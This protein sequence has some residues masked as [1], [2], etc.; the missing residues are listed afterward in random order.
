MIDYFHPQPEELAQ[1]FPFVPSNMRKL[2]FDDFVLSK[3][4]EGSLIA[5]RFTNVFENKDVVGLIQP[6]ILT[7]F[8]K[9]ISIEE[10]GPIQEYTRRRDNWHLN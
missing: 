6:E 1:L 3:V 5:V 7:K 2:A 9:V 10:L 8:D 4:Y